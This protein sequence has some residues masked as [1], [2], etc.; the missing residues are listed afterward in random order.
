MF[1]LPGLL[2]CFASMDSRAGAGAKC[3]GQGKDFAVINLYGYGCDAGKAGDI[4]AA[5]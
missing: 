2:R 3:T 5:V 4:Q 1:C